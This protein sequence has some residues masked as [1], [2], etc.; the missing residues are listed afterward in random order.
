MDISRTVSISIYAVSAFTILLLVALRFSISDV[1]PLNWDTP[2]LID[3]AYRIFLDQK[4][5]VDFSTPL[6]PIIFLA[7][8]IGMKIT[9]P[10]IAGLNVGY[11]LFGLFIL[12]VGYFSLRRALK[13]Q[14]MA[15]FLALLA[16][17]VFTP[18]MINTPTHNYGYTGNYNNYGYSILFVLALLL[19]TDL[20]TGTNLKHSYAKGASAAGL[21]VLLFFLKITFGIAA[22]FLISVWFTQEKNKKEYVLGTLLGGV[23]LLL[24]ILAWLDFNVLAIIRDLRFVMDSR[25]EGSPFTST[26]MAKIF[27][28][29]TKYDNLFI[30]FAL[31]A[32]SLTMPQHRQRILTLGLSFALLGYFLSAAIMQPPEHILS[33]FYAFSI[34][35][36][37]SSTSMNLP[38]KQIPTNYLWAPILK[39][40]HPYLLVPKFYKMVLLTVSI[41]FVLRLIVLNLDGIFSDAGKLI[42][43]PRIAQSSEIGY[44]PCLGVNCEFTPL[45]IP[46]NFEI[47]DSRK[48][49]ESLVNPAILK[50][51]RKGDNILSVGCNNIYSFHF[52]TV[53]LKDNLLFW[54]N[55]VTFTKDLIK[56][57]PYFDPEKI[58]RGVDMIYLSNEYGHIDS[59]KAF[60][61]SY[62]NYL[63]SNFEVKE[64]TDKYTVLRRR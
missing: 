56:T 26:G 9:T 57:E 59:V 52:L 31:I 17:M 36:L 3:G 27:F 16:S 5:H 46:P 23:S 21:F 30:L 48:I 45:H 7:G 14:L 6:G 63:H 64:N 47:E 53:P 25:A 33:N 11:I 55:T 39:R 50:W 61:D 49:I 22:I 41:L 54:H 44:K 15:L 38:A 4:P 29:K 28:D 10:T 62:T 43:P 18:R 19:F 8:A 37:A 34:L 58:F 35:V 42:F 1:I 40:V 24:I 60:V 13:P 32:G 20:R 2:I 12:I 51:Y